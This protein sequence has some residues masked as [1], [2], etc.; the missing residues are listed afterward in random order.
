[1]RY[2]RKTRWLSAHTNGRNL[3]VRG[4]VFYTAKRGTRKRR[5]YDAF[6]SQ[7]SVPLFDHWISIRVWV[8]RVRGKLMAYSVLQVA[9]RPGLCYL[10]RA[11]IFFK[12]WDS[13][14]AGPFQSSCSFSS[15]IKS[16][17]YLS[18]YLSGQCARVKFLRI[19]YRVNVYMQDWVRRFL[20]CISYL[21][22]GGVICSALEIIGGLGLSSDLLLVFKRKFFY[23]SVCLS[24]YLCKLYIHIGSSSTL[25]RKFFFAISVSLFYLYLYL[26][27]YLS[28]CVRMMQLASFTFS[29]A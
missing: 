26:Y 18:I 20:F 4:E 15:H 28:L 22:L 17:I 9:F 16:S 23:L 12:H 5:F 13:W 10:W 2:R 14:L 11:F 3:Q 21:T 19:G 25:S 27:L 6:L 8:N 7:P 24:I 29:F 1:L